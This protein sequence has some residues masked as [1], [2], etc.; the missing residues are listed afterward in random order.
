MFL[1]GVIYRFAVDGGECFLYK[2]LFLTFMG[3]LLWCSPHGY[4]SG[5]VKNSHALSQF[6]NNIVLLLTTHLNTERL[7]G[8]GGIVLILNSV[9]NSVFSNTLKMA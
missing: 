1:T 9:R 5:A 4:V 3:I 7:T 8:A 2:S 6:L